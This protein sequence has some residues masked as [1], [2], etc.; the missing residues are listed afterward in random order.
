MKRTR[1]AARPSYS[2][3]AGE[4]GVGNKFGVGFPSLAAGRLAFVWGMAHVSACKRG[5]SGMWHSQPF[6]VAPTKVRPSS[7][8]FSGTAKG[9][10]NAKPS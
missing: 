2:S 5:T 8:D 6:A 1:V 4:G 9:E 3:V 10:L 7:W